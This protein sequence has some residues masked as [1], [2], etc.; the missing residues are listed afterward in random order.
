M[1]KLYLFGSYGFAAFLAL[2][3]CE[4]NRKGAGSG[5]GS[6]A[7]STMRVPGMVIEAK[8]LLVGVVG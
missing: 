6:P 8:G 7:F 3:S 5:S 4:R 1:F 2:C